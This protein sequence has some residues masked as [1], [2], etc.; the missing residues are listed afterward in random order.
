MSRLIRWYNKQGD[1]TKEFREKTIQLYETF[2]GLK[3]TNWFCVHYFLLK[4]CKDK[5]CCSVLKR[6]LGSYVTGVTYRPENDLVCKIY[7]IHLLP[8]R[9]SIRLIRSIDRL[10]LNFSSYMKSSPFFG[11]EKRGKFSRGQ[12]AKVS[13]CN[14]SSIS[15]FDDKPGQ[16][17]SIQKQSPRGVL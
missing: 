2:H 12:L 5:I 8:G 9:F 3:I 6:C 11:H 13:K 16:D 7:S 10:D 1:I 4:S 17:E 15:H 14:V